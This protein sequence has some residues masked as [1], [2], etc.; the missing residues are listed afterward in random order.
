MTSAVTI[1]GR[2]IGPGHPPYLVA[3]LSGNHNGDLDR[4]LRLM[5]A[6]SAAGAD[7]IKLQ[8]Y[9]PDT[10]TIDCDD[11]IYRIEGGLWA[12]R[13]LYELY[14]EAQTPWEWHEALFAK[15]RDLGITVFSTPFDSTAVDFLESLDVPAYKIASFEL[16]DLPLVEKVAA[17][18]RPMIIS[19]GMADLGEIGQAVDVARRLGGGEIVLLHCVS[20]YP[21]PLEDA[22][23]RTVPHLADTFSAVA[24]LSDHTT[25]TAAAVA[26]VALGACVVEKHVTLR[27]ADGGPD[28]AFSLEPQEFD[29]LVRDC[30]AAWDA[31]GRI[32]YSRKPSE[33]ENVVF[34]RSLI[35]VADLRAGERFTADNVRSIRP[36]HGLAPKELP[37]VLGRAASRDIDRGTP[38]EWTM[39][40]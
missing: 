14:G 39:I 34:R 8:T 15:G 38:L 4:A 26:A 28:A 36:G 20:A 12:G 17:T 10:M 2:A 7:A 35:A 19:T 30:R 18:G 9:T 24:G 3:E 27:R 40:A 29:M 32:D 25:G 13:Q 22:N 1:G 33:R 37:N 16:I 23:V 6:A 31:L 5:Q 21:T 11:S